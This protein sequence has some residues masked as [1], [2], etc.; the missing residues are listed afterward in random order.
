MVKLVKWERIKEL[1]FEGHGWFDLVRWGDV[2]NAF[3]AME[4]A[5]DATYVFDTGGFTIDER[6][7]VWPI[8]INEIR[9]SKYIEQNEYY[10]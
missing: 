3:G 2:N 9:R 6:A 10:K 5:V 4:P 1:V 8:H 7:I